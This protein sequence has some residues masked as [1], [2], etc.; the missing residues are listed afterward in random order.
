MYRWLMLVLALTCFAGCGGPA[1]EVTKVESTP[2]VQ[3]L[4]NM[5]QGIEKSGSELGSGEQELRDIVAKIKETDA[6]KG[7]ELQK[8]MEDLCKARGAAAIKSAAKSML[9]KL[10]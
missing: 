6:A 9:S 3:Y 10:P 1:D 4:K 5:L 8:P 2:A 7:A